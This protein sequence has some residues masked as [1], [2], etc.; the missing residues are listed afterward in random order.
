[1]EQKE[2]PIDNLKQEFQSP[3]S[4]AAPD[5][6]ELAPLTTPEACLSENRQDTIVRH[7]QDRVA[8]DVHLRQIVENIEQ[9]FWLRD[10]R[11]GR[12]LYV[13]PAFETVWGLSSESLY[14][15]PSTLIESVHPEDRVKVISASPDD[16]RK[17][18]NQ[19]Y[20]IVRPDGGLRWISAHTFLLREESSDTYYQV[21]VAQDITDHN[22]VDQT[23]RRALDRSREQFTLSR[24]MSLTRKPEAVLKTLMSAYELRN[25][26]HAFVF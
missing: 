7:I 5:D 9:I 25:A 16:N 14:A 20:R 23:L 22:Q 13:S 10:M 12:V 11:T 24:R 18:L 15:D 8:N 3:F 1:M 19:T 6:R 2:T 26:K 4:H 17:P 21:S